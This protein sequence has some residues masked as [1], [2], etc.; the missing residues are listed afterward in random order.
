MDTPK[1]LLQPY[2]LSGPLYALWYDAG[3]L[4]WNAQAAVASAL[5]GA[6]FELKSAYSLDERTLLAIA[7]MA[8]KRG[9]LL[10]VPIATTRGGGQ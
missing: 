5:C 8:R 6:S 9:V 3:S 10:R 4:G 7:E 1:T 2:Q